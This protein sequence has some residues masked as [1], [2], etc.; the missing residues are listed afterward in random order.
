VG[1]EL[2]AGH[3]QP[4]EFSRLGRR[5]VV[6]TLLFTDV[7]GSVALKQ[8][9]GDHA[10]IALIQEHHAVIRQTLALSADAREVET[11]GDSFLVCFSTPSEAV[12]HAL[13]LRAR[14]AAFNREHATSIAD[15]IGVHMGEVE[16][17][18]CESGRVGVCGM[19]VDTCARVMSLAE[20]GQVLLTRPV[21]DNARQSLKGEAI[22]G[23][24]TLKCA[25]QIFPRW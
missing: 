15:R 24:G 12:R 11:A 22:P 14:L 10:G 23:C 19:Q 7:V 5:R 9:L 3:G 6:V 8:K 25:S 1:E 2:E 17:T 18:E 20:G 21:F 13:L 4:P 16:I